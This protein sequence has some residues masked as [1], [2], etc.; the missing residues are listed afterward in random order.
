MITK[1]IA[2]VVQLNLASIIA[3]V[4]TIVQKMQLRLVLATVT[5][6]QLM[7]LAA[8]LLKQ[9]LT[10]SKW[11]KPPEEVSFRTVFNH[12]WKFTVSFITTFSWLSFPAKVLSLTSRPSQAYAKT[13]Q[14]SL[15]TNKLLSILIFLWIEATYFFMCGF[16]TILLSSQFIII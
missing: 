10:K 4:L 2:S 16:I 7:R 8:S 15:R 14:A 3:P 13:A 11:Q 6:I 9:K 5:L 12:S 1:T